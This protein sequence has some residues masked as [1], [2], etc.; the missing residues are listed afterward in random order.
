MTKYRNGI[1]KTPRRKDI[2]E[3]KKYF[4]GSAFFNFIFYAQ[5]TLRLSVFA[6]NDTVHERRGQ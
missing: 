6:L 2:A 5:N 1:A 3:N 4:D